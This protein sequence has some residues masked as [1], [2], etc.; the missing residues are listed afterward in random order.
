MLKRSQRTRIIRRIPGS[1]HEFGPRGVLTCKATD[2]DDPTVDP[3]YGKVGKQ[4][5]ENTGA[6]SK[7]RMETV[8]EEFLAAAKDFI[9]RQIKAG[10]PWFCYFNT[11]R[12]H[13]FTHLK[14]ESRGQDR[15]WSLSRR[16]GRD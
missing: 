11:T 9:N 5:I 16:Y 4:V 15:A 13:V 3:A 8:D 6:L 7:K 1:R 2:K 14:K 10:K 12:M